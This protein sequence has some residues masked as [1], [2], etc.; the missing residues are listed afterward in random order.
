MPQTYGAEIE[1]YGLTP[2][3]IEQAINSVNGAA[4]GAPHID[5]YRR[6]RNGLRP[7]WVTDLT[8]DNYDGSRIFG[9]GESKKLKTRCKEDNDHHVWIAAQ[10][11]SI[12]NHAGRGIGHEIVSPILYGRQG[13]NQLKRIMKAL[14]R[15][16]AQVNKS[17]GFHI[18]VGVKSSSARARRM[19][20][21]NLAQRIGRIVDAYDW[22]YEGAFC[23]LVSASRR[24]GAPSATYYGGAGI[25][26][27]GRVPNTFGT[28]KKSHYQQM[29][30]YGVGRGA[31]N[32]QKVNEAASL[33]EFRQH[34]GSLNGDKIINF[35][36]LLNKLVS[37]AINDEHPNHGLDIRQFPPSLN[38]LLTMVNAGSDMRTA[39]EA[40]ERQVGNRGYQPNNMTKWTIH[41]AFMDGN[42]TAGMNESVLALS[43]LG[44][45]F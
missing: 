41:S 25:H 42:D 36:L 29:L 33:I 28:G 26:Y 31:V 16:G 23:R 14:K 7:L 10:D 37:W 39:L 34:N 30:R 44:G 35:A 8:S 17:C 27:T 38:G 20:A 9:Y 21:A 19:G 18:T 45:E 3:E 40:R 12:A 24:R 13:L 5:N 32:L 11:S 22:F 43:T 1:C 4:Y 15:A 6:M 2:R